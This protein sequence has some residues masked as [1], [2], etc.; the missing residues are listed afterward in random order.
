PPVVLLFRVSEA[1]PAFALGGT[2]D[3]PLD[4]CPTFVVFCQTE[5]QEKYHAKPH[6]RPPRPRHRTPLARRSPRC[7]EERIGRRARS[8]GR[9][10]FRTEAPRER[11][12]CSQAGR[13]HWLR[14]RAT[15]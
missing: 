9:L 3:K 2:H 5:T 7:R 6:Y 8:S 10:L 14:Q 4:N 15:A 13:H 12:R 11:F 1:L